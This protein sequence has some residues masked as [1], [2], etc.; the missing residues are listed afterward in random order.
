MPK[1]TV[2]TRTGRITDTVSGLLRCVEAGR[3]QRAH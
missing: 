2:E 1:I 3:N